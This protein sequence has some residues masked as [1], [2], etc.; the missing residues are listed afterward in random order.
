M[1]KF[2]LT[3]INRNPRKMLSI[4]SLND[5]PVSLKTDV[6]V[7]V[8]IVSNKKKNLQKKTFLSS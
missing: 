5:L 7:R 8:P 1:R 3:K 2:F 6:N 4:R